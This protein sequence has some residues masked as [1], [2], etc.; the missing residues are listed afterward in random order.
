[1]R[2]SMKYKTEAKR[3]QEILADQK[4]RCK[5]ELLIIIYLKAGF[6]DS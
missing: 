3:L 2:V 4:L 5:C 1:M 6:N